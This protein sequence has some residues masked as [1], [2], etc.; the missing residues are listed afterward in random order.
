[1]QYVLELIVTYIVIGIDQSS[2]AS[3]TIVHF[4]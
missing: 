4:E 1:M 3:K 2:I